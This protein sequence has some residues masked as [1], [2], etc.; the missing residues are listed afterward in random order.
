VVQFNESKFYFFEY[1][2]SDFV[3]AFLSPAFI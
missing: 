1:L 3:I 2:Y